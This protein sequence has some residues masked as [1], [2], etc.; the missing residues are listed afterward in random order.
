MWEM[1]TDFIDGQVNLHWISCLCLYRE[2]WTLEA[3]SRILYYLSVD[4]DLEQFAWNNN[5]THL[6]QFFLF[7]F[8]G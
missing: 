2:S 8:L 5:E 3:G 4:L 1:V 7:L 6:G